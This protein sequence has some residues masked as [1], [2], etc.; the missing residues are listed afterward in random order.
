M[1]AAKQ[2]RNTRDE[3]KK[4]PRDTKRRQDAP[5][6][7]QPGGSQV[8]KQPPP[9]A[10]PNAQS[11]PS[12]DVPTHGGET[13]HDRGPKETGQ[14]TPRRRGRGG[15]FARSSRSQDGKFGF[16]CDVGSL[17]HQGV[18]YTPKVPPLPAPEEP[19]Y[20]TRYRPPA[21]GH[22]PRPGNGPQQAGRSGGN[23]GYYTPPRMPGPK[24]A[25]F[26]GRSPGLPRPHRARPLPIKEWRQLRSIIQNLS[27]MEAAASA[28]TTAQPQSA[29]GAPTRPERV[30]DWDWSEQGLDREDLLPEAFE[31]GPEFMLDPATAFADPAAFEPSA[32][33]DEAGAFD[34][35]ELD[36]GA[37]ADEEIA[38]QM[39]DAFALPAELSTAAE[40]SLSPGCALPADLVTAPDAASSGLDLEQRVLNNPRTHAAGQFPPASPSPHEA[41]LAGM[42]TAVP[43]LE[44]RILTGP[45]ADAANGHVPASPFLRDPLG[46]DGGLGAGAFGAPGIA[47]MPDGVLLPGPD[48]DQRVMS[49]PLIAGM[50][51]LGPEPLDDPFLD[52]G[53][54]EQKLLDPARPP[55]PDPLR[56]F[57]QPF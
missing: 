9:A 22:A 10:K 32:A 8:G 57:W 48:L 34:M 16:S 11:P 56:G 38:G 33:F 50:E 3:R 2:N 41:A 29:A 53:G 37:R 1:M 36:A 20:D 27:D 12:G 40:H 24:P 14:D 4:A 55:G 30:E 51:P 44:Q 54:L 28:S 42:H 17:K 39:A 13:T 25:M 23:Q 26:D 7:A 18:R 31:P 15:G 52:G 43:D 47:P 19:R 35:P 5:V 46:A 6:P 21:E 49:D 45:F